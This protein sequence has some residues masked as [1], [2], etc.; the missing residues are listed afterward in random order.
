MLM[1]FYIELAKI[2]K[3]QS[4]DVIYFFDKIL[5]GDYGFQN[6]FANQPTFNTLYLKEDS[7]PKRV[8]DWKSKEVYT[9]KLIPLYTPTLYDIKRF[10]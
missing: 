8:T 7:G 1:P 4:V 9:S 5:F 10:G 3:L 6:M 2:E